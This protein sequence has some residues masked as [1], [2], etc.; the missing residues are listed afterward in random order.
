MG[1][2]TSGFGAVRERSSLAR[3]AC[4]GR[5]TVIA[6][7]KSKRNAGLAA[8]RSRGTCFELIQVR[9]SGNSEHGVR[10]LLAT[11]SKTVF[12]S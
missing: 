11:L 9:K 4:F 7:C 8:C 6:K 2:T 5:L 3:P 10:W 1:E 12:D